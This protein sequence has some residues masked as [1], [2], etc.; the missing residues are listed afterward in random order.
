M[1]MHRRAPYPLTVAAWTAAAIL[2]LLAA[3][4]RAS[5]PGA[6]AP[7]R[8]AVRQLNGEFRDRPSIAPSWTIPVDELGFAAPGPLYLG[9]RNALASLDF[10]S[11]DR[12][13]FTF[14][15]PAL[16]R[17]TPGEDDSDEREIRAVVL[18]IPRG[19][20]ESEANW[21]VHDRSRYLWI[22]RGG[23]FLLRNEN[24]L[25]QGDATLKLT[26]YLRFPGP[27]LSIEMNPAQSLLLTNSREPLAKAARQPDSD[28]GDSSTDTT[29]A[30]PDVVLRILERRSG[31]MLLVTRVPSAVQ[32]AINSDGYLASVRGTGVN[33]N[34]VLNFY[35][36]ETRGLGTIKSDC[37][38]RMDFISEREFLVTACS[39]A[40]DDAL[41]GMTTTGETLWT[42]L[43]PDHFVWPNLRMSAD[44]SKIVRET[45]YASHSINA[46]SPMGDQDIKGQWVQVLDA[47]T[48]NVI[49]EAP[50]SPILDAGGNVAISPSGRRVAVLTAAGIEVFNLPASATPSRPGE[51]H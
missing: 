37:M 25:S 28:A 51:L 50:A 48:G 17:R 26:P 39:D 35:T 38:P 14:R 12:L 9:Q 8:P 7:R 4:V 18:S 5:G 46:L 47:A 30:V 15:V 19:T 1:T 45:L 21:L 23:R 27:V 20:L 33:W 36:G 34:V 31:Q 16:L 43:V 6:P 40:G 10:L 32:P 41:M 44:G 49:F 42:D 24:S 22:L 11:E 13:L 29:P 3:P 2:G